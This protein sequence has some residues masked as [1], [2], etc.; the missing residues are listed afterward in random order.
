MYSCPFFRSHAIYTWHFRVTMRTISQQGGFPS[1]RPLMLQPRPRGRE[2]LRTFPKAPSIDLGWRLLIAV[3]WSFFF[4]LSSIKPCSNNTCIL[5]PFLGGP[6]QCQRG[7]GEPSVDCV[8]LAFVWPHR[9]GIWGQGVE[10][11]LCIHGA[12]ML[13]T[14]VDLQ[15]RLRCRCHGFAAL[16][17]AKGALENQ[18]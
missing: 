4:M 7:P 5:A 17:S 13:W 18:V 10:T 15:R 14:I 2:F 8:C 3:T 9:R 11:W 6:R 1:S 16:G 12:R